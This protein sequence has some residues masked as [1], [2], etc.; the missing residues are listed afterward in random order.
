MGVHDAETGGH[1]PETQ[2][3][4]EIEV[5]GCTWIITGATLPSFSESEHAAM[6]S[7][8]AQY[9]GSSSAQARLRAQ[10]PINR[11]RSGRKPR[12]GVQVCEF[13]RAR[14]NGLGG[15]SRTGRSADRSQA[16]P[17][18]DGDGP[19]HTSELRPNPS[20]TAPQRCHPAAVARGIRRGTRGGDD[21]PS[22]AVIG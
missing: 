14:G 8:H 6:A 19:A 7:T 12:G 17:Q 2:G 13:G 3:T 4:T 18:N 5:R 1:A 16:L 11:R 20:Q 10:S 9:Q 21:I 15:D 22:R